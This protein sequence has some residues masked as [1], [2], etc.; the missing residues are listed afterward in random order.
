MKLK[1]EDIIGF[2]G[3][4]KNLDYGFMSNFWVDKPIIVQNNMKIEELNDIKEFVFSCSEQIFMF[5][6]ACL[7]QDFEMAKKMLKTKSPYSVKKMGREVKDFDQTTWDSYKYS[8]MFNANYHKYTQ[9]E[10]LKQKLLATEDKI[11]AETSANDKVWGIGMS[12]DDPD[13]LDTDKWRGQN[14]LGQVL[15]DLRQKLL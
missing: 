9:D 5:E 14:L 8:I 1:Q 6:K 7:F 15:M 11:L 4:G 3:H 12:S 10:T 2:Y 13:L